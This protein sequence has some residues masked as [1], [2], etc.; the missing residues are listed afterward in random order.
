MSKDAILRVI[1]EKKDN[2]HDVD[3]GI[4]GSVVGVAQAIRELR[5]GLDKIDACLDKR[6]YYQAS[7]IGYNEVAHSFVFLQ[8]ALAGVQGAVDDK[9]A[10]IGNIALESGVGVYEE[11][12]PFVHEMMATMKIMTN[13]EKQAVQEFI[14]NRAK[15]NQ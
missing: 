7:T 5:N 12:A 6:D 2:I 3:M 4:T 13:E 14:A 11:V 1:E 9:E 15:D 8:R 10:L